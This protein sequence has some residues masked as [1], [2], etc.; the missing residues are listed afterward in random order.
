MLKIIP[1]LKLLYSQSKA[2]VLCIIKSLIT[3]KLSSMANPPAHKVGEKFFHMRFYLQLVLTKTYLQER[4]QLCQ[5][6]TEWTDSLLF[7]LHELLE[8]IIEENLPTTFIRTWN[9]VTKGARAALSYPWKLTSASSPTVANG[10][11]CTSNLFN[12]KIKA[13]EW[14]ITHRWWEIEDKNQ[15][16]YQM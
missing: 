13:E 3:C 16:V 14:A 15:K 10:F 5:R 9:L 1:I 2:K 4:G 7:L 6:N 12:N 11:T 8:P